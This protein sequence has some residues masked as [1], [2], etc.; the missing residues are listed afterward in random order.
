MGNACDDDYV[1]Y[2]SEID[3]NEYPHGYAHPVPAPPVAYVSPVVVHQPSPVV[4]RNSVP[5]VSY[6]SPVV[7]IR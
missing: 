4:V 5:R 2:E 7:P 6:H 3:P 1:D